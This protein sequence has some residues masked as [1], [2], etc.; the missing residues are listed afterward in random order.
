MKHY[1]ARCVDL[2]PRERDNEG[3]T[4]DEDEDE[5]LSCPLVTAVDIVKLLQE[6]GNLNKPQDEFNF[7]LLHRAANRGQTEI[8]KYLIQNGA[9]VNAR[10]KKNRTPLMEACIMV[11]SGVINSGMVGT[12]HF[13]I[14][15]YLIDNGADVNSK[16]I[17]G[18]TA[19]FFAIASN[20]DLEEEDF[21]ACI[22]YASVQK[23]PII[24][25]LIQKGAD[26]NVGNYICCPL[27][28]A[29]DSLVAKDKTDKLEVI[30]M[31]IKAGGKVDYQTQKGDTALHVATYHE[32]TEVIDLLLKYNSIDSIK[33]NEGKTPLDMK[34]IK[35]RKY[36]K[37]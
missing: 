5:W 16:D 10:S 3:Y 13:N 25:Y 34:G 7:T 21:D 14:I 6:K 29:V 32:D 33:N 30:E 24:E 35:F 27:Y 23:A 15:Q 2:F 26:V 28:L 1:L 9:D 36:R 37:L 18:T 31:L 22:N 8:V 11:D 17:Y 19:I 20:V 12:N 4:I